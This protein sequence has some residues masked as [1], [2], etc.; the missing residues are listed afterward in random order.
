MS[1]QNE[2]GSAYFEKMLNIIDVGVHL[3]DREG[4]TIFYNDKMAETDGLKREQVV[5][6]NFEL[7]LL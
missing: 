2:H 1:G 5:G 6:K 3:I 7:F 4:I